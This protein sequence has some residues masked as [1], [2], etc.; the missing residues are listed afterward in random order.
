MLAQNK[1]LDLPLHW[2]AI[3]GPR[4]LFSKMF[5]ENAK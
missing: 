4:D 3:Q 1:S 2:R 5:D